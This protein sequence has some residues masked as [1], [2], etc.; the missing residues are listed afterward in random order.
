MVDE[1]LST[2]QHEI[3]ITNRNTVEISGITRLESF[4]REEFLL[5]TECGYLGVRG[6]DLHIKNLDLDLGR[7]SIEGQIS[8]IS[9]LEGADSIGEKNHRLFGRLFR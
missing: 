2:K 4:D 8:D 3:I 7:I 5:D 1:T 6:Q 9:Y